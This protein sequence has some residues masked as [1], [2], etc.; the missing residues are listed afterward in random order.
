MYPL[1]HTCMQIIKTFTGKEIHC[2]P[3]TMEEFT[4]PL[5]TETAGPIFQKDL[6]LGN[7]MKSMF[8]I[9]H[10]SGDYRPTERW[11]APLIMSNHT[12]SWE[13]MDLV[14]HGIPATIQLYI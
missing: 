6:A 12:R 8:S 7:S 2:I 5:I 13:E 14:V 10:T 9:I 1:I 4:R 3:I 11:R